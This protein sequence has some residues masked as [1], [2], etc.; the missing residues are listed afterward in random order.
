MKPIDGVGGVLGGSAPCYVRVTSRL[1]VMGL[2]QF[3]TDDLDLLGTENLLAPVITPWV[4]KY[5]RWQIGIGLGGLVCLL[6][7]LCWFWI[8]PADSEKETQH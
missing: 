1:T 5:F 3:D 8:D 6:G 7:A 4:S 2:M